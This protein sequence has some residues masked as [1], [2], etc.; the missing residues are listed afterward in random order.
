MRKLSELTAKEVKQVLLTITP[1]ITGLVEE[2]K[3]LTKEQQKQVQRREY[4]NN[5]LERVRNYENALYLKMKDAELGELEELHDS[6]VMVDV[7]LKDAYQFD[8][9]YTEMA[10][11][12]LDLIISAVTD[13][14]V[15]Q[16]DNIVN[17]VAT[18][19]GESISSIESKSAIELT[20][21]IEEM[22]QDTLVLRFFPQLRQLEKKIQS[23]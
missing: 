3:K 16:F 18:L 12:G 5:R 11:G 19:S 22:L 2:I 4:L 21:M 17:I 13:L 23:E 15:N 10:G 14:L 7:D 20:D 9:V 8:D 1:N 6:V